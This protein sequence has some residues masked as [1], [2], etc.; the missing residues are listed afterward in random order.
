VSGF[1][2]VLNYLREGILVRKGVLSY[3]W[4]VIFQ[5]GASCRVLFRLN[6]V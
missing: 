5:W 4:L 1:V 3:T 2:N 6:L